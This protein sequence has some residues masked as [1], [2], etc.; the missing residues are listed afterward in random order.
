[1]P[2][3]FA[4]SG[5]VALLRDALP[6][7]TL[8]TTPDAPDAKLAALAKLAGTRAKLDVDLS[9]L[10]AL[11]ARQ[12]RLPPVEPQP[13][14]LQDLVRAARRKLVSERQREVGV[15]VDTRAKLATRLVTALED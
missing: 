6:E 10:K 2:D 13:V 8:S 1:M 4:L 5:R 11:E 9:V 7:V 14:K 3:A 15:W 12:S